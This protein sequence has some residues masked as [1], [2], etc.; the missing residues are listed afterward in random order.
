MDFPK[1]FVCEDRAYSTYQRNVPAPIFRKSFVLDFEADTAEILICGLGHYDL[2]LNGQ[3]ITKGYLAPYISNSDHY[4]YFDK[5]DLMP[6][7]AKGENVIGVMLGD[8]FQNSKTVLWDFSDNIINSSPQL[9]LNCSI[10]GENNLI[11][12][13]AED[14]L[15]TKGPI[16]FNDLR[17]GVFYDARLEEKGWSSPGFDDKH[18]HKPIEGIRP[19]GISKLCEVEP[20]TVRREISPISITKGELADYIPDR[21]MDDGYESAPDRTGGYIYDFGE[22]N[23]GIYRLKI[24]GTKGQKIS[25]QCAEQLT[26]GKVNYG[27]IYFY[28][29]GFSQRDIYYV[30]GED[31][32]VFEPMFTYH[33]YR[34][35]YISGITEEQ[36][37]KEL[38]TYMV[39]SSDLEERGTFECSNE[40]VNTIYQMGR[41]SDISNFFYFPNDCPHREKNGWTADISLSVEHM[42]MTIGAEASLREWMNNLRMAQKE[43]GQLPGIVPTCSWGYE[44]GNGPAWDCVLFNVPYIIYKY[45]GNTEII[46]ENAASMMRYLDYISQMR[47][48]RGVVEIG[49][50]DWEPVGKRAD[51]FDAELGFTNGV[52]IIDMCRKAQEMFEAVGLTLHKEFAAILEREMLESVRREYIDPDSLV[53]KKRC[54]TSQAMAIYYNI[55]TEEEKQKGFDVLLDIIKEDNGGFTCGCL[56]MRVI[57]HVLSDFGEAELAYRM[58]TRSEFPS[59]R[60]W[61]DKGETT[62]LE[63]FIEYDEYYGESKNHHFMGDVVNWFMSAIGGLNVQNSNYV[64]ISPNFIKDINWCK[65]THSLPCGTIKIEWKRMDD[66]I[67]LSVHT[68]GNVKYDICMNERQAYKTVKAISSSTYMVSR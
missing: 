27:N 66:K 38:L 35:I 52:M 14:F 2:F 32:E 46:S 26:E 59:Y 41:R 60:Y 40:L 33:G 3:K 5:Y 1:V 7:I 21:E 22:N 50:G 39:M 43:N 25:I 17:S 68:T 15:C 65:T 13:T 36:A 30:G 8:G 18:W 4:V 42:I 24:K 61:V 19:R 51:M 37:T 49:L 9:A 23:A 20:V 67:E 16:L 54:Q 48:D 63:H 34:Y 29:D 57:F 12:F 28:P 53:V 6:Y 11:E 55:F 45:R 62:F 44:W 58:I 10:T 47:D 31:E 64:K 56:G